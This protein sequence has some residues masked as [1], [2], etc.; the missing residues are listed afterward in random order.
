VNDAQINVGDESMDVDGVCA[1]DLPAV[2]LS[3]AP[4]EAVSPAP[5]RTPPPTPPRNGRL[6][7]GAAGKAIS[8]SLYSVTIKLTRR[9]R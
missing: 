4:S 9:H 7:A 2:P 1:E 5:P 3:E 8:E 6:A